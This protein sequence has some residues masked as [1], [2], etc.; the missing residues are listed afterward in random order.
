[1]TPFSNAS[2]FAVPNKMTHFQKVLFLD[3]STLSIVFEKLWFGIK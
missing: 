3:D 2:V 1:M